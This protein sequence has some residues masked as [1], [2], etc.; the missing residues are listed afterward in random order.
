MNYSKKFRAVLALFVVCAGMIFA[1]SSDSSVNQNQSQ[2]QNLTQSQIEESNFT[3]Q[4]MEDATVEQKP[5][6]GFWA[7]VRMIIVLA[8]V[9]AAIYF[10]FKL[11]KKSISPAAE[12]D[13]FLR[14]VSGIT[15]S[16]GLR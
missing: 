13:P 12:N 3:F 5:V 2:N 4:D 11:F 10:V 8:I 1:Q 7:F 16:P 9:I 15:L 14:K 6:S